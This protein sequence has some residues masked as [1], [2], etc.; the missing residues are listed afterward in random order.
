[1][2]RGARP[3]IHAAG[4][5]RRITPGLLLALL[6]GLTLG[7]AVAYIITLRIPKPPAITAPP[8]PGLTTPA[9]RGPMVVT[10][11]AAGMTVPDRQAKLGPRAPAPL[12]ELNVKPGDTVQAGAVLAKTDT[13]KLESK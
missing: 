10:L 6:L 8:L 1:M 12:T 7:I 9:R 4:A 11:Q 5:E 2:R 3:P 13:S